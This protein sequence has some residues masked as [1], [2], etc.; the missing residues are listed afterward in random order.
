MGERRLSESFF[1]KF[2]VRPDERK[3]ALLLFAY[4]FLITAPHTIIKTLRTTDLLMEVGVGAL[5]IAYL[6][7]AIVTGLAVLLQTRIQSNV[8]LR[9]MIV[10]GL[11][12]FAGSGL[13][14]QA[15]LL[16]N[17]GRANM[18]LPYV[19]WVWASV[20]IVVLMTHYWMLVNGIFNPREAKRL[21]S[22]IGSGGIL[23]GV[24]GGLVAGLLTRA[25][26]GLLLLPLACGLL[27]GCVAV[28]RILF[29][30]LQDRSPAPP[31]GSQAE[32][33]RGTRPGIMDSLSTLRTSPYLRLLAVIVASA[34][35]VSTLIE[36]QF[37]SAAFAEKAG[38]KK[39]LQA[40][41]GFFLAGLTVL[42]FLVNAL[43]TS[44]ILRKLLTFAVLATPVVLLFGAAA[45]LVAPF[46]LIAVGFL[47]VGDGS[48]TFSLNQ[49]V[50]EV[51]YIPVAADLKAKAKPFIDMFVSQ[52]AKVVGALVLLVFAL[53][54]GKEIKGFTPVFNPRLAQDL[55]WIVVGFLLLWIIS[56]LSVRK[57]YLAAIRTRIRID[58]VRSETIISQKI[59]AGAVR[60]IIDAVDPR[61]T[62]SVIFALNAFDLLEQKK[63]SSELK[64][65]IIEKAGEVR[66]AALNEMFGAED[67]TGR[68]GVAEAADADSFAADI[69]EILS[70]EAYQKLMTLYAGGVLARGK[71]AD[72]EKMELAKA[73]GFMKPSAPLAE[74]LP[75]LIDDNS[76]DVSSIAIQSAARLKR[77]DH[78]PVI[79]NRLGNALT[80][81]D[82]I[83]ALYGYGPSAIP[84]LDA[85]LSDTRW[86]TEL[87]QGIVEVLA[88]IGTAD[89]VQ[90]L[91]SALARGSGG[92]DPE[93]IDALDL[94]R[95]ENKDMPM[96][97]GPALAKIRSLVRQYCGMFLELQRYG[98][99]ER[100]DV[101]RRL[102]ERELSARIGDIF[103][104]LGLS[105]PHADI[106]NAYQNL[107]TPTHGHAVEL[108]DNIL[109]ADV[110]D[111][112]IPLVEDLDE[113]ARAR[114]FRKILKTLP[115]D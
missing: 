93:I 36:F 64:K 75:Q 44:R 51:L 19:Y 46:G 38:S 57:E 22:F 26:L 67:A 71:E 74:W 24:C 84:A 63:L 48:L 111:L 18:F 32:E 3:L 30:R 95:S 76:P 82:A 52:T 97:A 11:L 58:A 107:W 5:P 15:V 10:S 70:L 2:Q 106:S 43:L 83:S 6:M 60:L 25:D 72:V 54:T 90:V 115:E 66:L 39:E 65:M 37:L 21:V 8:S 114:Q 59:D 62:S 105:H 92:L 103:K 87:R 108:L 100:N 78:I 86:D 35:I 29:R 9:V 12:F 55:G 79:I 42:A 110:K 101:R 68:P 80:R 27:L 20:L 94:I 109:R 73:I 17:L 4:F 34:V 56:G 49:S 31:G 89:A 53:M 33:S 45:V 96:P 113:A 47:K 14:L 69:H 85:S 61:N 40:F 98:P 81:A 28:V 23:G 104:L 88:R 16:A 77:E 91:G 99:G 102:L 7:A 50:R 13:V 112:V 41:L 1:R